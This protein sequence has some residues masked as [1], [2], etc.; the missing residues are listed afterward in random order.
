MEEI[1]GVLLDWNFWYKDLYT[2]VPRGAYLRRLEKLARSGFVVDIIGI[3]RSGKS[4]LMRQLARSLIDKGVDRKDTLIVNFED[5]RFVEPSAELLERIYRRYLEAVKQGE[6]KPFLFLD[7]VHRAEGWEGFVRALHERKEA[8]IAVSGSTSRLSSKEAATLLTGRHITVEVSPLSFRE[9]LEFRGL[10][11]EGKLERLAKSTEIKKLLLE[12]MR[13][14][15]FP[16]VVLSHPEERM[17]ILRSLY[18]DIITRDVVLRE[19][20]REVEKLRALARFFLT[21]ISDRITFNAISKFLGL[22][23]RTV[24]RFSGYL[25]ATFLIHFIR[26]YS[27]SLKSVERAPRK[28]Y[29]ADVGLANAVGFMHSDN[30][31]KL[32]E[33]IV[34]LELMMRYQANPLIELFYWRSPSGAEVDFLVKDGAKLK[35]AM[36]V[37]WDLGK[38]KAREREIKALER[39]MS[40]TGLTE[41][42][43]ITSEE[44]G[45][46]EVGNGTIRA[47]PLWEWLLLWQGDI[48]QED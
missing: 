36:Q 12:Y 33:N 44:R 16:E 32:A 39:L 40:E 29:C 21:N 8:Q 7:E 48:N 43:L 31:G 5:P 4:T 18:D 20:V 9:F 10:R 37:C 45:V 27:R 2:G 3:R 38:P 15:G 35:E 47:V 41:A 19:G 30:W 6:A 22:P 23:L 25:E 42:T 28:V 13:F 11:A 26:E 34:F 24:E 14:G 46:Q 1:E 17:T